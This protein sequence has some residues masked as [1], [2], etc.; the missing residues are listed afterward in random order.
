MSH[1][2]HAALDGWT[3]AFNRHD[4]DA[5]AELFTED[6]L[7]QGFGPEPTEGRDAVRA[8]YAVVPA[9]RVAE[10]TVLHTYTLGEDVAGGYAD[11]TIRNPEG[12]QSHVY[13]SL[14]VV[15]DGAEWRIRQYHV[16]PVMPQD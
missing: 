11:V 8:Y 10:G 12:P 2:V 14:V 3:A 9:D 7:F 1:P 15:R 6:A 4:P 5:M 16:S 13:M